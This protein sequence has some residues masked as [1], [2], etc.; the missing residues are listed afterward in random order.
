MRFNT[1]EVKEKME[2]SLNSLV[3]AFASI[4][5]SQASAAV[6][7]KVTFD[8]WGTATK[9]VDMANVAVSDAKTLCIT[10]Y[11]KT[12]LKAMV[13]AIQMSD[14][15][16]N[17]MDDGSCIR[18]VFPPLTEEHRKDLAKQV[19]KMSEEGKVAIRNIRRDANELIKKLKKDGDMTEDE[20]KIG[21]K[22][23]QDITDKYIKLVDEAATKKSNEIMKI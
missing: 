10:P 20:Q 3:S 17:P 11:D 1:N 21:E 13:K 2:K 15:G 23:V 19:S 5:A 7:A 9:I 8:Y 18:L 4:R 6:V 22:D 16:I 14:I 12:T